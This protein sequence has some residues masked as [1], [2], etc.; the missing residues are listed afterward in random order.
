MLRKKEK[1]DFCKGV[2]DLP[3]CIED[4]H[5]VW[6]NNVCV[7]YCAPL[8]KPDCDANINCDWD[9]FNKPSAMC[10][11]VIISMPD[12]N[13]IHDYLKEN[14]YIDERSYVATDFLKFD[15]AH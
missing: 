7:D 15:S 1:R 5:C 10:K 12:T 2:S 14:G 8:T 13:D 3:D 11:R 6:Y 9:A 4:V